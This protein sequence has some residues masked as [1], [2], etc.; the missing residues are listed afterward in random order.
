MSEEGTGSPDVTGMTENTGTTETKDTGAPTLYTTDDTGNYVEFTPPAAPTFQ[1]ALPEDLR[2]NEHLK[3]VKDGAELARYYVDL[4]KDYLRAPE[5]AEGYEFEIPGDFEVDP[6]SYSKFRTVAFEN[7]VNQQQF[8]GIMK[9]YV[10]TE[11]AK[12]AQLQKALDDEIAATQAKAESSLKAE[13]GDKYEQNLKSA[14][15]ILNRPEL[16]DESFKE[17]LEETR[18]GDNPAVVKM[19]A[20][21]AGLISE[22]SFIKPGKGNK[23]D[24]PLRDE[25]GR[26]MLS[27][28]SMEK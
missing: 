24:G 13:W 15:D 4:K 7:G 25:S 12:S 18:F 6:D 11:T 8:E 10:E 19:F 28:P 26:P 17:F 21:I 27:F 3:E 1:E 16:I 23:S 9:M 2:E 14:Q 5:T 20:K 22:D